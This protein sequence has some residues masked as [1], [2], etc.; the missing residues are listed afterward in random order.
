M[1]STTIRQAVDEDAEG[2]AFLLAEL[3]YP[4]RPE[5]VRARIVAFSESAVDE[6]L[7]AVMAR[8]VVGLVSLNFAP[9]FA[10][11]ALFARLTAL[12]IS[13][14]H[15]REGIARRL[16][17]AAEGR[18]RSAGCTL[19]QVNCGRRPERAA[20]HLLYERLGYADSSEHHA[21][22]EKRLDPYLG[23]L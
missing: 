23:D 19:I 6:V 22:Y 16:V 9:L 21:H 13:K 11:G 14:D 8:R 1:A 5:E 20:A 12:V 15:R 7:V 10:E 4:A 18:A 17:Q 3:G 2:A